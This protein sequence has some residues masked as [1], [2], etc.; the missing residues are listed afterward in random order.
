MKRELLTL[1]GCLAISSFL[2]QACDKEQ[3]LGTGADRIGGEELNLEKDFGGFTTDDEAVMFNNDEVR[4]EF[5]EDGSVSDPVSDQAT[6]NL[7]AA[8]A[9]KAIEV[10]LTWGLLAGDPTAEELIDWSGMVSVSRGVLAVLKVIRFESELQ[11]DRLHLPRANSRELAFSSYADKHYDGL[12]LLIVDDDLSGTPGE[13]TIQ[14]GNYSRTFTFEELAPLNIVEPVGPNANAVSII[15]R[16]RGAQAPD[17][18]FLSGSWLETN[19]HGGRFS[20]RW[21]NSAG[22][23]AGAVCGIWGVRRNGEQVF[24]GKYIGLNG[25]FAGLL[26][27]HW[28]YAGD[29]HTGVFEGSWF[30]LDLQE[31][32]V[33]AGNFQLGQSCEDCG[34]FGGRWFKQQ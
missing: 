1:V 28:S 14:A 26:G 17:G 6:L 34:F 12:L 3:P 9:P 22:E 11:G 30:N 4:A 24:Y 25:E 16:R 23:N 27:G 19:N 15:G 18:G 8:D 31:S 20:G 29:E 33:V 13:F 32:G 10:R 2:M 7:S 5:L 21:I